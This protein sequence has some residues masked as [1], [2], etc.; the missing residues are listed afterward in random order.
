MSDQFTSLLGTRRGLSP[1]EEHLATSPLG[2]HNLHIW[3][4]RLEQAERLLYL[5]TILLDAQTVWKRSHQG[6]RIMQA[7]EIAELVRQSYITEQGRHVYKIPEAF[8]DY[9]EAECYTDLEILVIL[10]ICLR[11][12]GTFYGVRDISTWHQEYQETYEAWKTSAKIR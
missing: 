9:T 11:N 3:G 7:A 4:E 12:S 8:A 2:N 10:D 5:V 1:D 6:T